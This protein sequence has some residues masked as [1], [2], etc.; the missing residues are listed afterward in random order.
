M[1]SGS[2]NI[3]DIFYSYDTK[4]LFQNCVECDKYLL[5][6]TTEYFIE[7]A[8]R[9]YPGF[10][11]TDVV[12]EY[13]ICTECAITLH[14]QMSE[15]SRNR[16]NE[17]MMDHLGNMK[18]QNSPEEMLRTCIITG[19]PIEDAQ[20][21]QIMA[22]CFQ[23]QLFPQMMPYMICDEALDQLSELLSNATL[24]IMD[25]F[26]GRHFGPPDIFEINP[27]RRVILV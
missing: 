18:L 24:D 3:P 22:H 9:K 15:E 25:D 20:E 23:D 11:A 19:K 1:E 21:Y 4:E 2:G 6:G 12:F 5:D 17:F 14:N 26:R 13:A 10:T 16:I 27:T 8:F 7:K